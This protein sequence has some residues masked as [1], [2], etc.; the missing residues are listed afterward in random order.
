MT[1]LYEKTPASLEELFKDALINNTFNAKDL[2]G[3]M[4]MSVEHSYSYLYRLQRNMIR[5]HQV[6]FK[7][8]KKDLEMSRDM[9]DKELKRL[10]K[11]IERLLNEH[12]TDFRTRIKNLGAEKDALVKIQFGDYYLDP[13]YRVCMNVN[14][15]LTSSATREDYRVSPYWEK[16]LS[17][18]EIVDHPDVFRY[19]PLVTIDG[20]TYFD[21]KFKIKVG[22]EI[23]IITPFPETFMR[24]LDYKQKYHET[25]FMFVDNMFAGKVSVTPVALRYYSS[26]FTKVPIDSVMEKNLPDETVDGLYFGFLKFKGIKEAEDA[27]YPMQECIRDGN[28]FVFSYDKPILKMIKQAASVEYQIVFF[29]NLR[30]YIPFDGN[31]IRV[32]RERIPLLMIQE[33]ENQPYAMPIPEVNTLVLKATEDSQ[34]LPGSPVMVNLYY[35]NIY[36]IYDP[37]LHPKNTYKLYYFYE[38]DFVL[39]YTPMH[40]FFY[41]YL[42]TLPV[43]DMPIEQFINRLF[44]G[45]DLE[46]I[47]EE[48]RIL[49]QERFLEV[50]QWVSKYY[51]ADQE[52]GIHDFLLRE[53]WTKDPLNYQTERMKQFVQKD[54]RVLQDYAHINRTIGNIHHLYVKTID[55]SKRFRRSTYLSFEDGESFFTRYDSYSYWVDG[56]LEVV[57]DDKENFD[58]TTMIRLRDF[59]GFPD[60]PTI[61]DYVVLEDDD[62]RYVFMMKQRPD[63]RPRDLRV[64]V[65]GKYIWDYKTFAKHDSEFIYLPVGVVKEDSYIMIEEMDQYSYITSVTFSDLEEI[66]TV[67]LMQ[68]NELTPYMTDLYLLEESGFEIPNESYTVTPII[69]HSEYNISDENGVNRK[70]HA[71]ITNFK[72]Q[73]HDDSLLNQPLEVRVYKKMERYRFFMW[74]KAWPRLTVHRVMSNRELTHVEIWHNGL[75]V[76]ENLYKLEN[77]REWGI[78]RIQLLKE[79]E[80]GDEL[81]IEYSPYTHTVPGTVKILP[82]DRIT[83]LN[84][85][86]N[87]PARIDYYDFYMNG[88]R[89]GLPHVYQIGQ[90]SVALRNLHSTNFL[91]IRERER[92]DEYFGFI[93]GKEKYYYS[94]LDFLNDSFLFP[95]DRE[96]IIQELIENQKDERTETIEENIDEELPMWSENLPSHEEESKIFYYEELLPR[97]F[98]D[99]DLIQFN[100]AYFIVEYPFLAS[101]YLV[102]QEGEPDPNGEVIFLN[103]DIGVEGDLENTIVMLNGENE[104]ND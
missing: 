36:R 95:E 90:T 1:F 59:F 42:K 10:D 92:D 47:I 71:A 70:V 97:N 84:Q 72:L 69:N 80:I 35:P 61:G 89:L 49:D 99:P 45:E 96:R 9:I 15:D 16:E 79:F 46:G 98:I 57:E 28:Y 4:K 7:T 40:D 5:F 23:T 12:P 19:L 75:L 41:R 67:H 73:V 13:Q 88:K 76:P 85:F 29:H 66:Q 8:R 11:E 77:Y 22:G 60:K 64:F 17:F 86:I 31:P 62:P 65:D 101:R 20:V 26:D 54:Y 74:R 52:Y 18:D 63:K 50:F 2:I 56:S 3:T 43:V 37:A 39:N 58:Y 91:E 87:K 93:N 34:F 33:S 21:F 44:Y 68:S 53:T 27:Y 25:H 32:D 83:D 24:G 81:V 14:F 48:G 6:L 38:K 100:K 102:N 82:D 51:E 55:L 94:I 103:P 30:K 78:Y 104:I